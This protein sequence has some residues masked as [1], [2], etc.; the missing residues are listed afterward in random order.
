MIPQIHQ[1]AIKGLQLEFPV[2]GAAVQMFQFWLAKHQ[3][4]GHFC[5]EVIEILVADEFLNPVGSF[6][7]T[8]AIS[9]FYRTLQR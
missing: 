9:A 3:L 6:A 4:S 8:T 2:F 7:P 5:V 1:N